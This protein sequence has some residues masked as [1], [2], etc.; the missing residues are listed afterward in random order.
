MQLP[1]Q[2]RWCYDRT[3][4]LSRIAILFGGRIAEELFMDQMTTGAGNDIE[5]ASDIARRMVCEW[6]MSEA[7]GPLTFRASNPLSGFARI[8][9]QL[10][11]QDG[12]PPFWKKLSF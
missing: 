9:N 3:Y 6:G 10:S 8:Y 7:L 11:S 4:L 5:R 1:E 12:M 2:D